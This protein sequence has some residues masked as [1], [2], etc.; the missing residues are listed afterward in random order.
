MSPGVP[1]LFKHLMCTN[2]LQSI[3]CKKL[4]PSTLPK[5]YK[6]SRR[7][8]VVLFTLSCILAQILSERKYSM[9]LDN[10][11][12]GLSFLS[13]CNCEVYLY[14]NRFC[15]FVFLIKQISLISTILLYIISIIMTLAQQARV[16]FVIE[17]LGLGLLLKMHPLDVVLVLN[18][19]GKLH[20]R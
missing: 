9:K 11:M 7:R 14:Q 20:Y 1:G 13:L 18:R 3:H 12:Y 15:Q 17:V 8:F 2:L 19:I 16:N 6:H 4:S 10:I 5:Q